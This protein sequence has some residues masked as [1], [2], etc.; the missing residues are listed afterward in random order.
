MLN[1]YFFALGLIISVTAFA[2]M[3][4]QDSLDIKTEFINDHT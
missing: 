2:V 4:D 1:K 3:V